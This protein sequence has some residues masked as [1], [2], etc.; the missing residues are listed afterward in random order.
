MSFR[1]ELAFHAANNEGADGT[2][3]MEPRRNNSW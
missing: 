2:N 3:V 1:I